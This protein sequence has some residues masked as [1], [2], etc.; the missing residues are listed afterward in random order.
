MM[1]W[2]WMASDSAR[3]AERNSNSWKASETENDVVALLQ[4][5]HQRGVCPNVKVD[6][7]CHQHHVVVKMLQP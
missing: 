7:A 5:W 1:L 6:G 2:T 3:S 4:N